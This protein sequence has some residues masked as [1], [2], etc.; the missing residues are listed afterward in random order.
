MD[1]LICQMNDTP[2][3]LERFLRV[4]R[5]KGFTVHA[6]ETSLKANS[7]DIAIDVSGRHAA[8]QLAVQLR[9]LQDV[10]TLELLPADNKRLCESGV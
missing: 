9:K 1:K 10:H 5:V 3:A 8:P 2:G 6:M 7:V 4:I